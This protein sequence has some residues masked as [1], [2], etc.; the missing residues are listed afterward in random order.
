MRFLL[1][2]LF[3]FLSAGISIAQSDSLKKRKIDSLTVKFKKDSLHTF[4]FKTIRP[5]ANYDN[6]NSFIRDKPV[7]FKGIQLGVMLNERHVFGLGYYTMTDESQRPLRT[8]EQAVAYNRYLNLSYYTLFYQFVLMDKRFLEIDL[9]FEIGAGKYTSKLQNPLTNEFSRI[10]SKAIFPMGAAFQVVL[11]PVRW[12]GFSFMG[13]YRYV[14]DENVNLNF[15]GLYYS[16]GLWVDIRQ[17]YRDIKFYGFVKKNYKKKV[18]E[19]MLK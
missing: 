14:Y 11:K 15:N 1:I 7:N 2:F 13:G 19:I 16:F 4:R 3:S 8:Q 6:R 5:F 9:P 12:V 17:I 10:N 18:H